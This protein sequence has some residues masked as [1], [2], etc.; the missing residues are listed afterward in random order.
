MICIVGEPSHL[1]HG[2]VQ[3]VISSDFNKRWRQPKGQSRIDNPER[4]WQHWVH[5]TQNK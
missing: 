4:Y 1:Y 3:H 5:K 2:D